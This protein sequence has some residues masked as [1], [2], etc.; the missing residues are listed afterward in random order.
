MKLWFLKASPFLPFGPLQAHLYLSTTSTDK[1]AA[2]HNLRIIVTVKEAE[3]HNLRTTSKDIET[4]LHDPLTILT[5][6]EAEL[7]DLRTTSTDIEEAELHDLHTTSTEKEAILH[8]LRTTLTDK[9]TELHNIRTTSSYTE[10]ELQGGRSRAHATN[11]PIPKFGSCIFYIP[12]VCDNTSD[13]CVTISWIPP[14]LLQTLLSLTIL[15]MW[16]LFVIFWFCIGLVLQ[17]TKL[18]SLGRLWNTWFFCWTGDVKN[19]VPIIR[20]QEDV[21]HRQ[22]SEDIDTEDFNWST[23]FPTVCETFPMLIYQVFNSVLLNEF[24]F[25]AILSV[26]CSGFIVVKI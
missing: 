19:S 12:G 26:I 24:N 17:M 21:P 13:P 2:A 25:V 10:T 14:V 1:E 5:V 20:R 6:K 9:E 16:L 18:L 3:L 22:L 23:F 11:C 8:N 15:L 7:H 4:E